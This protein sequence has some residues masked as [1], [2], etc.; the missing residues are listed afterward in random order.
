MTRFGINLPRQPDDSENPAGD[1]LD[2]IDEAVARI[3]DEDIEMRLNQT[4]RREGYA[5][6]QD[7]AA[8][9][10]STPPGGPGEVLADASAC[11]Q[12]QEP[13]ETTGWSRWCNSASTAREEAT[14][15]AS[16]PVTSPSTVTAEVRLALVPQQ[17]R[18]PLITGLYYSASDPYAVRFAFH[19]GLDEPVEWT[20]ARDLLV[21]GTE[22]CSGFGDIRIW[23]DVAPTATG[24]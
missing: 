7:M 21:I 23:P 13:T 22:D 24:C 10:P 19:I 14:A 15:K 4:L 20:I 16:S 3:T 12:A 2:E 17:V 11:T 8:S 6:G 5:A 9:S 1:A 18:V